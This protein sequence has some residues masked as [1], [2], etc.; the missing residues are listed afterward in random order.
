MNHDPRLP[1][2]GDDYFSVVPPTPLSQPRLVAFNPAAAALID[3]EP[4]RA[5]DPGFVEIMAG[6]APLPGGMTAKHPARR[7]G[8]P[9]AV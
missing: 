1:A 5:S 9:K 2:L 3:L 6:N 7:V 8:K 4:S